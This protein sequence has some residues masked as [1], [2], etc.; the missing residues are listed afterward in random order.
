MVDLLVQPQGRTL[1]DSTAKYWKERVKPLASRSQIWRKR[2]HKWPS[3]KGNCW[4]QKLLCSRRERPEFDVNAQTGSSKLLCRC[5]TFQRYNRF[6]QQGPSNA[7]DRHTADSEI[8]SLHI[9]DSNRRGNARNRLHWPIIIIYNDWSFNYLSFITQ[10]EI[11][12]LIRNLMV[13]I[14]RSFLNC[15]RSRL[16]FCV[17]PTFLLLLRGDMVLLLVTG[18]QILLSWVYYSFLLCLM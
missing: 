11:R 8:I 9:V 18:F 14:M 6:L 15:L 10:F 12:N 17:L 1:R 7:R 13:K 16:H 5:W 4:E 3:Q 2:C